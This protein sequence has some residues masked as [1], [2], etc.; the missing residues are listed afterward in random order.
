MARQ[1]SNNSNQ[2]Q[3]HL[4]ILCSAGPGAY[5]T[6]ASPPKHVAVMPPPPHPSQLQIQH[7]TNLITQQVLILLLSILK[8]YTTN[9]ISCTCT[10]HLFL[11]LTLSQILYQIVS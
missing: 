9:Y 2:H 1:Y 10:E 3:A 6:G 5:Q 8:L 4:S 11:F 7:S